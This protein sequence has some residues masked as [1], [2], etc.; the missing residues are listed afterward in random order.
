MTTE[1]V[2]KMD[3]GVWDDQL[4]A[5]VVGWSADPV[6]NR[7]TIELARLNVPNW[8]GVQVL[9]SRT[10]PTWEHAVVKAPGKEDLVYRPG[11]LGSR[12]PLP[13]DR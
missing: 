10:L 2:P 1:R 3:D 4:V 7:V 13:P 8:R 11:E 6:R 9:A 5:H 12:W